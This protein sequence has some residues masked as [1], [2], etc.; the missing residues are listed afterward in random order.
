MF[1][2]NRGAIK[3]FVN[4]L[5]EVMIDIELLLYHH[6]YVVFPG[7]SPHSFQSKF[8]AKSDLVLRLSSSSIYIFLRLS[9]SCLSLPPPHLV[10]SALSLIMCFRRQFLRKMWPGQLASTLFIVW[11]LF[12][13]FLTLYNYFFIFQTIC[14]NDH[15][16]LSRETYFKTIKLFL[17]YF[18]WKF[19]H[20]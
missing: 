15:L 18:A 20:Y 17:M 9:S 3:L 2:K 19:Q 8:F 12:R 4:M 5:V 13:F 10:P 1:K 11:R 7:P 16:Y 14:T 6:Y